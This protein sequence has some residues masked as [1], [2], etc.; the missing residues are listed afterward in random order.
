MLHVTTAGCE[1]EETAE[2]PIPMKPGARNCR[3][4][5][6]QECFGVLRRQFIEFDIPGFS[7][8][9]FQGAGLCGVGAAQCLLVLD[10]LLNSGSEFHLTRSWKPPGV[11]SSAP[12]PS[13]P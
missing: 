1:T 13:L 8:K 3:P 4:L 7:E 10:E 2:S 6:W 11:S 12:L 9:G 5:D